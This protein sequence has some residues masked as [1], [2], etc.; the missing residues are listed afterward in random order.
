MKLPKDCLLEKIC[1]KD[2]T[3][4]AIN[5]PFLDIKDGIAHLIGTNG[6][7]IAVIPVE[8]SQ[9]DTQGHIPVDGLKAARKAA[10]GKGAEISAKA[11]GSFA[12]ETGQSFPRGVDATF[13]NWRQVIPA[14]KPFVFEIG[15]D[16]EILL[17]LAQA[18]GSEGQVRLSFTGAQDPIL[19]RAMSGPLKYKDEV[20]AVIMPVRIS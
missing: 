17:N 5:R 18:L 2:A 7:A 3:R 8:I 16:A 14:E 20:K 11:N 12:L 6:R 19:V 4:P 1:S 9:E 15:L 10:K 13:P